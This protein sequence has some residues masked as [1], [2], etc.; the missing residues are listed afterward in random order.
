VPADAIT[1][2]TV[3]CPARFVATGAGVS[4]PAPGTTVLAIVPVGGAGY[5]FRIGN[6]GTNGDRRITVAVACRKAAARGFVLRLRSLKTKVVVVPPRSGASATLPCPSGT[7]AA[8]GGVDLQPRQGK[9]SGRFGGST[10]SVRRATSTPAALS[11][12][13][14]NAG[15]R[16]RRVALHGGCLTFFRIAGSPF[17]QLHVAI[18]TFRIP[19]PPGEQR[20]ARRCRAG[21]TPLGAGYGL[22]ARATTVAAAAAT[23]GGG[24]WT[25]ENGGDTPL[26]ADL[27]LT[28]ARIAP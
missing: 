9:A 19:V 15:S 26:L 22:R 1:T 6:P 2:F 20:V 5:R 23:G 21:W 18:T 3:T 13:V 14:A 11:Y 25:V 28:C 27:Q 16:P 12:V 4:S 24:R 7:A 10:L 8:G 17:E